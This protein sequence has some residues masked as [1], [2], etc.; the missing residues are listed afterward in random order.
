MNDVSTKV[1]AAHT[2]L[3]TLD[4]RVTEASSSLTTISHSVSNVS[5]QV[6][7][8]QQLYPA[9]VR[10]QMLA[11]KGAALDVKKIKQHLNLT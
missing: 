1:D 2:S 6:N 3:A 11:F 8:V 9:A 4:G 5:N 7:K 10:D